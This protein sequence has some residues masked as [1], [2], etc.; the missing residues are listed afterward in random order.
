[1]ADP[2]RIIADAF[3]LYKENWRKFATA[4]LVI[5]LID[6]FFGGI[7]FA[8]NIVIVL[9]CPSDNTVLQL[10]LCDFPQLTQYV[11]TATI[12]F[13]D[14]FINLLVALAVI[15]PFY[16]LSERKPVS[17][18]AGHFFPQLP[19]AFLVIILRYII[20]LAAFIPF[21]IVIAL[22]LS[23]IIAI[24]GS[25]GGISNLSSALPM[26]GLIAIV[27]SAL[28]SVLL[29]WAFNFFLTFLEIEVV[30]SKYSVLEA[31]GA[32]ISIVR[33]NLLD[34]FIFDLVW[35]GVNFGVG[36]LSVLLCCTIVLIPVVYLIRPFLIAPV[37]TLSSILLWKQLKA[38]RP[39]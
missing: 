28:F 23:A 22:N 13:I 7:K 21:G 31:A 12:T 37:Q 9:A 39:K 30:L 32:S 14:F 38:I 24:A 16:E 27:A 6:I 8:L 18:W 35:V 11:F 4:Y 5:F 15:T 19:N 33:K 2:I 1:M 10:I 29:M 26:F 3:D 36:L 34:V 17:D 25:D 20:T